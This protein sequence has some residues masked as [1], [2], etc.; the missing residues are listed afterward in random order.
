MQLYKYLDI[1]NQ[2]RLKERIM[3]M[4]ELFRIDIYYKNIIIRRKFNIKNNRNLP[5]YLV[6][7]LI[8]FI[9]C[10]VRD[11][12]RISLLY[13]FERIIYTYL[14]KCFKRRCAV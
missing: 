2:G 7:Y 13:N 4:I 14:I 11:P 1:K 5:K 3:F 6:I 8:L 9:K 10:L 12:V